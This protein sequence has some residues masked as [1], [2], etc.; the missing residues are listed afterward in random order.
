MIE[1]NFDMICKKYKL[2][3]NQ[4]TGYK[5]YIHKVGRSIKNKSSILENLYSTWKEKY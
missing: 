2:S 5:M 1:S 3:Q 4:I